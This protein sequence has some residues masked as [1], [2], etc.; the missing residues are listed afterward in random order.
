MRKLYVFAFFI[1]LICQKTVAQLSSWSFEGVTLS[2]AGSTTPN[3][4]VGS[5]Q[6]DAGTLTAGSAFSGLHASAGT[7][8]NTP[9]GN[10]SGKSL[11]ANNWVNGDYFQFLFST[12][13]YQNL[14]ITWDATGSNTGPR[15]FKVQYSTNGST[16]TDATGT[17]STYSLT[18]DSWSSAGA[19]Q[20]ISTRTLNL[21]AVAA[22]NNQATVYIRLVVN[23]NVAI[24]G[25]AIAAAGTSR[26]DNFIVNGTLISGGTSA[27]DYFRSTATGNWGS[28]ST[29]ESSADNITN[30]IAA[31][32]TPTSASS[33][34]T[35]RNSHTVTLAASA[36]ADQLTIQSGGT[37]VYSAGT[38][39]VD[40]GTGDDIVIQNGGI[41][42]LAQSSTPPT[43][44]SLSSTVRVSTG[45][46]L[47]VS[48]GGMTGN[49]T[50]VNAT[51]FVYEHQSILEWSTTL[52]FS[53]G[54]VTFFPNVDGITTPI[55]RTTHPAG[56]NGI[57]A[58]NPTVFNGVFECNGGN[59]V[60]SGSGTKTFRNGIRGPGSMDGFTNSSGTFIINGEIAELGGTGTILTPPTGMNIGG[61]TNTIVTVTSNKLVNGL[62]T[63]LANSYVRLGNFDLTVTNPIPSGDAT[64]HI[65]TNG[66]G[67][68]AY[69]NTTTATFPIGHDDT[70]Y[71]PIRVSGGAGN[72]FF[73]RVEDG[74]NPSIAFPAQAI[75]KTWHV[76]ASTVVSP[77]GLMFQYNASDVSAGITPHPQ[78]MEILTSIGLAW[79][80]YPG[81]INL[82]PAGSDPYT[83]T[84]LSNI[85]INSTN[86]AFALGKS[87]GYALPID[88]FITA[89][90]RKQNNNAIIKWKVGE[91]DNI[92]NF[93]IQRGSN[94]AFQTIATV[95]PV[96]NQLE[97]TFTDLS[98][99]KGTNLY[100][101]KVNRRSGNERYSN[102][103]A[104]INDSRD[105]VLNAIIPN[106]VV[107][108]S[109][110][111]VSTGKATTIEF[112]LTDMQGRTIRKWKESLGE[113]VNNIELDATTLP[114][115]AYHISGSADG[116]PI[117]PMRFVKQ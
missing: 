9:V 20:T 85:N 108:T 61:G 91:T 89:T 1:T 3:I 25:G 114:A 87:G 53:T 46:T 113:G 36:S 68:L 65:V 55:F 40:N 57:G 45:G 60:W 93:E 106:P 100:R 63:L 88:F 12:T 75:N 98:I 73:T 31:T 22:L 82:N 76:A 110:L 81:N 11:G 83:I 6:A 111:S 54:N 26:V 41:F 116:T 102:T 77:V 18:N 39:T 2:G 24:T 117:S 97:Y 112:M 80:L 33:G 37:L 7:V 72:V 64:R 43:F 78:P 50:G 94:G 38:F 17:N 95:Q 4:T 8:W 49:G 10:G 86:Q 96:T 109:T 104:V 70:H 42:E 92:I 15:D 44:S 19:P 21:N 27:T 84:S 32:L 58:G 90:A 66:T 101:I 74:I 29:W 115:G 14:S 34:I 71:N 16:F 52:F 69:A 13:G 103:I 67:R 79:S 35:I 48:A 99:P 59:I 5:A 51:N 107:G 28:N 56:L 105:V 47:K 30:W 62:I 23:S